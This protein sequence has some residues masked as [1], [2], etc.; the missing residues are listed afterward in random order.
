MNELEP[1]K[2]KR[3]KDWILWTAIGLFIV[4]AIAGMWAIDILYSPE[5]INSSV[6]PDAAG[7]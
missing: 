6:L 3:K 5:M 1:P 7:K 2:R 4:F